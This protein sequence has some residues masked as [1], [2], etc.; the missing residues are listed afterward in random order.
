MFQLHNFRFN[1]ACCIHLMPSLPRD[2]LVI[3]NSCDTC[4]TVKTCSTQKP[5]F[6]IQYYLLWRACGCSQ[7]N[8]EFWPY[9]VISDNA[10]AVINE[11]NQNV[12]W[13]TLCCFIYCQMHTWW[14][15]QLRH[16]PVTFV[17]AHAQPHGE[18]IKA[19]G[20][21]SRKCSFLFPI[22]KG[23]FLRP[24]ATTFVCRGKEP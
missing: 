18:S 24:L 15:C 5:L 6:H 16:V 20:H 10:R 21:A 8:C 4:C 3:D 14:T 2:Y 23:L 19:W 1:L 12:C 7:A 13:K 22:G 11:T 17:R 9:F